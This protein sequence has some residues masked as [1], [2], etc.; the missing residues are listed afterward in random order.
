M[1][2]PTQTPDVA[3]DAERLLAAADAVS[4]ATRELLSIDPIASGI[5]ES[6]QIAALDALIALSGEIERRMCDL[7][8]VHEDELR[9]R[10]AA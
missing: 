9:A 6:R 1:A 7:L 2:G 8:E 5:P 3:Q 10:H 4:T